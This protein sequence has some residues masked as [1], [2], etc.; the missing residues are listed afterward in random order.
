[1]PA[2]KSKFLLL[3]FFLFLTASDV[4]A[5]PNFNIG[6]LSDTAIS[7]TRGCWGYVDANGN[8]YAL[9]C[10]GN[11]LEIW[12]VTDPRNPV[13]KPSV[14]ARGTDLKQVR[15]YSHYALAVNQGGVGLQIIDMTNPD[16]AFTVLEYVTTSNL[17][18][19]HTVHIDGHYA[20]LGMN[21]NSPY[22]WRIIDIAEPLNPIQV[23]EYMTSRPSQN[24]WQSHDS[25]VN[26][27]TAY[28]AFLSSGFSIVDIRDKSLPIRI[29]DILYPNAFT[30]NCWISEDGKY[31]FTTDEIPG[32]G[33]LRVWDIHDPAN[34]LQVAEW[35][36]PG[37]PSII[38]N[39]QVKGNFLYVAYYADGVVILDI[40]DPVQPVEVGHYDTSP[41]DSSI[42]YAG[43]WDFFPYFPSGNLLASNYSGPAGMS[44]LHFN[45]A[46][47]GRLI[48]T[49]TDSLSGQ[50][51]SD[52]TLRLLGTSFRTKTDPSGNFLLHT[53][54][55][56][57]DLEF[58]LPSFI[59]ETV[60]VAA[61]F[62][63][64]IDLGTIRLKPTSFLPGT[65]QNL[66][67]RPDGLGN[68]HLSWQ[69]PPDANLTGFRVYRTSLTDTVNF[70]LIA[71]VGP[72]ESTYVDLGS[73]PGERFSYRVAAVNSLGYSS[74]L[75]PAVKTM[76]MVFGSKI[77][78]VDRTAYCLPHLKNFFAAQ[79]SLL[80]FHSRL[81]RRWDFDTLELNDCEVRFAVGPAFVSRHPA[82]V[83][84]S[85]ELIT[86]ARDDNPSFLSF[87]IDYLKAGGKLVMEGHWPLF[88][89]TTDHLCAFNST[90]LPNAT[91][92]IWDSVRSAFGFD[93]LTYPRILYPYDSSLE[94]HSFLSARSLN[95]SYPNLSADSLR[96][97]RFAYTTGGRTQYQYPTVPNV[98]YL[99]N[100][101]SAEDLYAFGSILGNFDPK[102][103]QP[104]AKKH[105]DPNGGGFVWF[106]FPLFFMREDSAKKAFRQALTDLGVLEII[107]E[108]FPKGDLNHNGSRDFPDIAYLINYIF[109]GIPFPV[110]DAAEADLNCDGRPSGA[111]IVWFLANYFDDRPLPCN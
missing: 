100:R 103:G 7:G 8:E 93:C 95:S 72:D 53:D 36:P 70:S 84:H 57:Y 27:D 56:S 41:N 6:L 63:D 78:L 12:D 90:F 89:G 30:H 61:V 52:V 109:V 83:L 59:P 34:P 62:N 92:A 97:V 44:L 23:G 101:N 94:A 32:S 17:G 42:G 33:H 31:L 91:T 15:P 46:R 82:I 9:I 51:L 110:F 75:S 19:A 1:M 48:G 76:R 18:G 105:I 40:E 21:G 67:A 5:R 10:A 96:V 68:I 102:D 74:P 99:D 98:G 25:Y 111:D 65:P 77:L 79:D 107:P 49:V 88:N 35:M 39:V 106:H 47:A 3:T 37:R 4:L 80:A 22:S 60:S 66:N 16:S 45:G 108:S 28:I 11:R 85:S 20:Y 58:F 64:T 73:N 43:C 50:L 69:H 54:S 87:F 81:L 13:R 71:S 29:A 24:Y 104:V 55:G 2:R 86:T 38:H 14:L 26:G